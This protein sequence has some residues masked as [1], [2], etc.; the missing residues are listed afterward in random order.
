VNTRLCMPI[1]I[2]CMLVLR[3]EGQTEQAV[4]EG[5]Q[6]TA[7]RA[8]HTAERPTPGGAALAKCERV[9]PRGT[10]SAAEGPVTIT[11]DEKEERYGRVVF[12]HRTHAEMSFMGSGCSE[13]HHEATEG[14]P[15]RKCGECH[16]PS[17]LR[18][19]LEKPDLRGAVHRQCVACH[20]QWDP[21]TR[22]G[23][24]HATGPGTAMTTHAVQNA[25][26]SFP[27]PI[28]YK[29]HKSMACGTCHKT[30][31]ALRKPDLSCESCHVGWQNAFDH[32]KT[33]LILDDTHRKA[34][35]AECHGA[36]IF[37]KPPCCTDCHDDKSYPKDKPGKM[38][39]EPAPQ[40]P[41]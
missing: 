28:L 8:C 33:G 16:S 14:Q 36:K 29:F 10:H 24:C 31:G 41:P 21:A 40:V 27:E 34:S 18:T 12:Q 39:V 37:A 3:S 2:A 17:R 38:G 35:C 25:A 1:A 20:Q 6:A 22:C 26:G 19:D 32:R 9:V 4:K 7:C 23:T 11:M 30:A 13:C 5:R 15:M